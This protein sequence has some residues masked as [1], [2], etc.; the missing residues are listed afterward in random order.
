MKIIKLISVVLIILLMAGISLYKYTYQE[1]KNIES[2]NVDFKITA[3][4]LSL[5]FGVDAEKA[6]EKYVNKVIVVSGDVSE[7]NSV[8]VMLNSVV[9]CYFMNGTEQVKQGA[10]IIKGR[11]IG[12]DDLLE[13]VKLDQCS[14]EK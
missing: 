8:S 3:L 10:L 11:C 1:H 7:L 2:S 9:L 13:V 6:S 14:F 5:H 12:Y 4:E